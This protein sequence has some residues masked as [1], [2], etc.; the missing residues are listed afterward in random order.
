M[1]FQPKC[2]SRA[3]AG[4]LFRG[5]SSAEYKGD[6]LGGHLVLGGPAV[7]FFLVI[8]L[9]RWFAPPP[10]PFPLTVFV[11]GLT[12]DDLED[13]TT[14]ASWLGKPAKLNLEVFRKNAG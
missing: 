1:G 12:G 2:F 6:V 5:L 3:A 4:S 11:H 8:L 10:P 7:V 9:G 14:H 13:H